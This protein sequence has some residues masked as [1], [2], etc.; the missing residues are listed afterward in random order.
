MEPATTDGL[1]VQTVDPTTRKPA[2][3]IT[4]YKRS[5][6]VGAAEAAAAAGLASV[7]KQLAFD[8]GVKPNASQGDAA[9]GV[10]ATIAAEMHPAPDDAPL[11]FGGGYDP[12]ADVEA[13]VSQRQL[14]AVG[15]SEAVND[16]DTQEVGL[17]P[18]SSKRAAAAGAA[19]EGSSKGPAGGSD[20]RATAIGK[21]QAGAAAAMGAVVTAGRGGSA[22]TPRHQPAPPLQQSLSDS[23]SQR[24]ISVRDLQAALQAQL[25]SA[26]R[27]TREPVV[28]SGSTQTPPHE[29]SSQS[30][31]DSMADDAQSTVNSQAHKQQQLTRSAKRLRTQAEVEQ[32]TQALEYRRLLAQELGIDEA[33]A[34]AIANNNN[35]GA[36]ASK[37]KASGKSSKQQT[38]GGSP[39]SASAPAS[40]STPEGSGGGFSAYTRPETLADERRL[41]AAT[42][43]RRDAVAS[44]IASF[45]A[46]ASA[47]ASVPKLGLV[48][49]KRGSTA[50]TARRGPSKDAEEVHEGTKYYSCLLNRVDNDD[51]FQVSIV[52]VAVQRPLLALASAAARAGLPTSCDRRISNRWLALPR[53]SQFR[54]RRHRRRMTCVQHATL[55]SRAKAAPQALPPRLLL[56]LTLMVLPL[57]SAC[58]PAPMPVVQQQEQPAASAAVLSPT[59]GFASWVSRPIPRR[60]RTTWPS[61]TYTRVPCLVGPV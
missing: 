10:G 43:S 1:T 21:A 47:S 18:D 26:A 31:Q 13:E 55:S 5:G 32:E 34:E 59:S 37:G 16:T 57:L 33:E 14:H 51:G 23:D 20:R 11:D 44:S 7:T 58:L 27:S 28:P 49:H 56:L 54:R 19:S 38:H 48:S 46:S 4:V 30:I 50:P 22:A 29:A 6:R 53:R 9:D 39:A 41:Q 24:S 60:R 61:H 8:N 17:P 42:Q 36:T 45:S 3:S 12:E 25:R 40:A 52:T 35:E 2:P 15:H